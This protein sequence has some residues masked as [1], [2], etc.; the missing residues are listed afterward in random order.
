MADSVI[1]TVFN[2]I[3][4]TTWRFAFA[5]TTK[6]CGNAEDIADIL[7][8]AYA[9]VYVVLTRKGPEYV[10]NTEAFVLQVV[11]TKVYRHYTLMQRLKNHIPLHAVN[12]DG[13]DVEI[14]DL[15]CT[16]LEVED[17]LIDHLFLDEIAALLT[18]RPRESQQVFYLFYYLGMTIP[19]ISSELGIREST[20]KSRI[21]RTVQE[22][23]K[24]Y[25]KE[26]S[27]R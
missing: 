24:H 20:V 13:E 7:Q 17:R 2:E 4:K 10:K 27:L 15:E 8:E 5:Y 11:K 1:T 18:T 9:E 21:Y 19:Q 25:G 14:P 6:K 16:D 12:G 23:R 22:I 26:V 3:Y